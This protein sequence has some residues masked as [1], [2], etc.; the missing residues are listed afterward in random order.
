MLDKVKMILK[1]VNTVSTE[2]NEQHSILYMKIFLLFHCINVFKLQ[3]ITHA[4]YTNM[5]ITILKFVSSDDSS[6]G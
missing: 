2:N 6:K 4:W 5:F 1:F 3:K